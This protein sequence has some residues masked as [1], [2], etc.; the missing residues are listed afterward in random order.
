MGKMSLNQGNPPLEIE[1]K[2]D[3]ATDGFEDSKVKRLMDEGLCK[4]IF[5]TT[6]NGICLL[7]RSGKVLEVNQAYCDMS[8]YSRQELRAMNISDLDGSDAPDESV[9]H[10]LYALNVGMNCFEATH[11][12]K[13]DSTYEVELYVHH[14]SSLDDILVIIVRDISERRKVEYRL[15]KSEHKFK[16]LFDESNDGIILHDLD[17]NIQDVNT[18][19]QRMLGYRIE[20]FLTLQ[21]P[22]LHPETE[23]DAVK[24]ALRKVMENGGVKFTT[25]FIRKNGSLMDAEI[26]ASVVDREKGLVQS[27]IRD[28]T[29]QKLAHE[30]LEKEKNLNAVI[31]DITQKLLSGEYEAEQAAERILA[32]AKALTGTHRG[33]ISGRYSGDANQG[34]NFPETQTYMTDKWLSVPVI[35]G[36]SVV[37]RISL[38]TTE[39]GFNPQDIE[40]IER[41]ATVYAIA[42]RKQQFDLEK[43]K[44]DYQFFQTQKLQAINSL[45]G[46]I[47]DHFQQVCSP[48]LEYAENLRNTLPADL[49]SQVR[50]CEIVNG[51]QYAE[52]MS[53]W[54]LM[55][56]RQTWQN[57]KPVKL[58]HLL[59][60]IIEKVRAMRLPGMI[61]IRSYINDDCQC[62]MAEALQIET[63]IIHLISNAC[64]AMEEIGGVLTIELRNASEMPEDSVRHPPLPDITFTCR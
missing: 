8:G 23:N 39:A 47:A 50:A 48:L 62:V 38:H 5:H 7:D 52:D 41:L 10:F 57:I 21:I 33:Y 44:S 30:K 1:M 35:I 54:L 20:E 34:E 24:W 26:S 6:R 32:Y 18:M 43:A 45:A 49:R 51:I 13:D 56:C 9:Q 61:E 59:P 15:R 16:A 37:S 29:E 25:Q 60:D 14:F 11:Y 28:I 40:S 22:M 36:T 58:Q 31:A 46:N 12:R 17:G 3:Q 4:I 63:I 27:L 42:L 2:N 55:F 64:G 19:I 53:R